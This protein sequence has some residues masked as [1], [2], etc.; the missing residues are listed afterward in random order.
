MELSGVES[1]VDSSRVMS[2]SG[3]EPSGVDSR[4]ESSGRF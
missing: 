1:T 2:W 4:V 3:V